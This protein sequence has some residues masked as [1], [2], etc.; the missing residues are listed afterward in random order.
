MRIEST[1]LGLPSVRSFIDDICN[2]SR[3]KSVV[4][5][6]PDTIS[7]VMVARLITNRL[8]VLRISWR[9]IRYAGDQFPVLS[10]CD[11]LNV[12]WP[13]PSIVKNV[14]NLLR[15]EDLPDLIHIRD[16][17]TSDTGNTVARRR[18]LGLIQ[19]WIEESRSTA[20]L[21][22]GLASR[23]FLVAKLRDFD[24]EPPEE[25]DGLSIHWWWGFPSSLELRLACRIGSQDVASDEAEN[26]WREQ[27]LPA[28]AGTDFGLAEQLWD[29]IFE[30][31]EEVLQTLEGYAR[32][33]RLTPA[34]EQ[35]IYESNTPA[36]SLSPPSRIWEQWASGSILSTP[37]YGTEYHPA[38][39]AH[40][41]RRT[42]VEQ[43]L[44]R[45]Q[46]ELLLPILNYVRIRICDCLTEALGEDWPINPHRPQT[47]YELEAVTDDP[48]GAEFGHIEYLLK[49]IPKFK[50]MA[51]LLKVVS[52][53]RKL[54]NEIAHYR[55]IEFSDFRNLWKE[56]ER[57][58]L[59]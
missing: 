25:Q 19:E 58:E 10:I 2:A 34:P 39:L 56:M 13:L 8:D 44:W 9:D 37:E 12:Q 50:D 16:F 41:G 14:R 45:G 17:S 6:I 27:V 47:D 26:R 28:I 24:F 42:D 36:F 30:S 22:I 5:L 33:K 59:M 32:L 23:L 31:T 29:D 38:L 21:D 40:C 15:C 4:V 1:V 46:S 18:W 53:S 43:R 51:D 20:V 48:R 49:Y 57:L 3:T 35:Q 52:M 55:L 7:R 54:R 11:Q